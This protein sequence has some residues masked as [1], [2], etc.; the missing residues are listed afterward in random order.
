MIFLTTYK[1]LLPL[2]FFKEPF[3]ISKLGW[4]RVSEIWVNS[5][6]KLFNLDIFN[7]KKASTEVL[8]SSSLKCF[9]II[10]A[11]RTTATFAANSL[12]VW[13]EK[14]TGHLYFFF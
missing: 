1:D 8:S 10:V 2:I 11:P 7:E 5:F 13:S 9:S 12:V 4:P 14:P 3:I 6:L